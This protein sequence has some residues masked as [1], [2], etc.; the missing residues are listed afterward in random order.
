MKVGLITLSCAFNYGAVLQTY[1]LYSF[2]EENGFDAEVIDYIPER[3]NLDSNNFVENFLDNT[4]IWK[5]SWVLKFIWKHTRYVDMKDNR[6]NFRD[7]V[8]KKMKLSKAYYSNGEL[9]KDIPQVDIYIT[10]SDQ[11][12]N[13]DFLWR[14]IIDLPYYLAFTEENARRISYASSFGKKSLSEVEAELVKKYLSRYEAISIR[15][16]SGVEIVEN[17]GLEATEVV[18]PTLLMD[19]V[20]Y[21]RLIPQKKLV[22]DKYILL[23]Q[24][25]FNKDLYQV[26]KG[27]AKKNGMKLLVLIPDRVQRYKCIFNSIILP[28][29]EDWLWYIKNAEFIITDSFHGTIFSILMNKNFATSSVVGC[30]NR[31]YNLLQNV[32]LVDRIMQEISCVEIDKILSRQINFVVVKQKIKSLQA[33]SSKWLLNELKRVD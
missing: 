2:L 23:F 20:F 8:E 31:I 4:R 26:A 32:E 33:E 18:D 3:Y 13:S 27:I 29:V 15:E 7:F 17:L 24:I 30:N 1:A 10:G 11:V 19:E 22:V 28:R 12:W 16:N 14:G 5:K 9:E 25:N 6:K 21:E